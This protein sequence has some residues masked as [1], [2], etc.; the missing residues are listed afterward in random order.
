MSRSADRVPPPRRA[1][2]ALLLALGAPAAAAA[3]ERVGDFALLDADG[4]FHQLSRYRHRKALAVMAYDAA[5]PAMADALARYLALAAEFAGRGADFL[6]IDA[7]DAGRA[8]LA[9]LELPLPALS[10]PERLVSGA[11][12]LAAAGETLLLDPRRLSL[13]YRGAAD[14]GL[15]R[16][17]AAALDGAPPGAPG[18]V[19][20]GCP[21]DYPEARRRARTPPDYA[22]EVAPLVIEHCG[23]CHRRGGAGPFALDSHLMVLGWSPMIREVLLT[24]RM[25]PAQVDPHV[26]RARNAPA[27]PPEAL[28]TLVH[29]ID[30]GAPRGEGPDPLEALEPAAALPWRFGEP[31]H[32][33]VTARVDVPPTGV[34]DYVHAQ[35]PLPFAG[36]RWLRAVQ[37]RAGDASVLHHLMAFVTAPDEDFWGPER[38]AA[39]VSRRFVAGYAPGRDNAFAWP[40]GTGVRIPEGH[41]LSLQFHYVTNGQ[42]ASD[43]TEIGL[44]FAD[45]PLIERRVQAVGARF[46]LPPG[47]RD[48]PLAASHRFS[49]PV[50]LTGVRARM[51]ARGS[52]MRFAA[53][54][55]DGAWRELLSVPAYNYG[56]QSHYVLAEPVRLEAGGRVH[57]IGALDNSASNP[58]NPD[59]RREVPFGLDSWD[60]MFTG[61]F[62]YHR[63]PDP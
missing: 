57:V 63:A 28:A 58:A 5:C 41:R 53:E 3:P 23:G 18:A 32:V 9:A 11:L 1:V 35:A 30:Q 59:P 40:D 51:N 10:D 43:A 12:G 2:L 25:P 56:W 14:A 48:F 8:A 29:W 52:R 60:E 33:V 38:H 16:A 4:R 6:L 55:P 46:T 47:A 24:R 15:A 62:S 37:F 22:A 34:M 36:E 20:G 44:W 61:Y 13:R 50:V 19:P 17:L 26:G 45:G 31:D 7:P 21:L 39:S 42:A 49:E 54:G 27:L